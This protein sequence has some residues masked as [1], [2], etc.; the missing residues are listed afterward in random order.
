LR[1]ARALPRLLI[2]VIEG[3]VVVSTAAY[4]KWLLALIRSSGRIVAAMMA[5]ATEDVVEAAG[6]AGIDVRGSGHSKIPL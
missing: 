6:E 1:L 3:S 4:E 2:T 5:K